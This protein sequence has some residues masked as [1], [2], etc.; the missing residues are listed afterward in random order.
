MP[1]GG[2]RLYYEGVD[3]LI[4]RALREGLPV[5]WGDILPG[6]AQVR[7]AGCFGRVLDCIQLALESVEAGHSTLLEL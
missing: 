4:T 3:S 5:S 1:G 7:N 6:A 2:Q